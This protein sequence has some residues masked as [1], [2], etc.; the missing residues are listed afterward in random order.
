MIIV[1]VVL[2]S[3]ALGLGIGL[4]NTS[5]ENQTEKCTDSKHGKCYQNGAVATDDAR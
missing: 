2:L 4:S 3:L 5:E 1:G